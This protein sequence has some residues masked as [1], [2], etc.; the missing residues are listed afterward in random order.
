MVKVESLLAAVGCRGE[1]R[2]VKTKCGPQICRVVF[3]N[4]SGQNRKM[5]QN[6]KLA[7]SF[8]R[9]IRTS[10]LMRYVALSLTA[11]LEK[12]KPELVVNVALLIRILQYQW[13]L[14]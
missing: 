3:R 2:S 1:K 12:E 6:A 9:H 13:S 10:G 8:D 11:L 7:A 4:H 14:F 5:K